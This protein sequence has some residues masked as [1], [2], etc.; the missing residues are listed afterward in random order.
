MGNKSKLVILLLVQ[1]LLA[2]NII[3]VQ[4]YTVDSMP[5][6]SVPDFSVK[7]VAHPY[8]VP[9]ETTTTIDQYTGKETTTT[10]PG[11]QV[12]NK[13]IEIKIKNPKFTPF[14]ITEYTPVSHY[15]YEN[16]P[17]RI[18]SNHTANLYYN[19]RVKGHF[20]NDWTTP[21]ITYPSVSYANVAAQLDSEYT[22]IS[23][24]ADYPNNAQIDFQVQALTGFYLPYGRNI[25]IFGYDFYGKESDWSS[26]Q[27]LTIGEAGTTAVPDKNQPTPTPYTSSIPAPAQTENPPAQTPTAE[28]T[29]SS[30]QTGVV[31]GLSLEQV[32]ITWLCVLVVVLVFLL[33][34]SRRRTVQMAKR[35]L[36]CSPFLS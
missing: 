22:V 24:K 13:S 16:A 20:G 5:K 15:W 7:I 29:E 19:V 14:N 21:Q 3:I 18:K 1:A 25:M 26:I 33:V 32:A 9:P 17:T 4:A 27:T 2:S 36:L 28:P 11:Y 10:Q 6:P 8:D 23:C 35:A 34:F 12:E 30:T 31:F